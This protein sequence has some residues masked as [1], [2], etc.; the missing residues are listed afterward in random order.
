[1]ELVFGGVIFLGAVFFAVYAASFFMAIRHRK[2]EISWP[3]LAF[4]SLRLL[5]TDNY[6]EEGLAHYRRGIFAIFGFA[7]CGFL[8]F[9]VAILGKA[10]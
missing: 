2:P 3:S 5:D 8:A 7:I 9:V 6:T 10:G 4:N 1:M